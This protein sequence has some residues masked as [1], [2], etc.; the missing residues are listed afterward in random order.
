V[1]VVGYVQHPGEILFEGTPTLLNAIGRAGLLS[2]TTTVT[3]DGVVTNG[4][5][6]GIPEKCTIYRGNDQSVQ[7]ELRALLTS[8]NALAD[9]RL[10]RNDVVYV[11]QPKELFVS[12]MGQVNHPGTVPLTPE[13]TLTSILTQAGGFTDGAGGSP[14]IHILQ[15][16]VGKDIVVPYK[17][18]MTLAGQKE[19]TLHSGDVI[20]INKTGFEKATY[21]LQRISPIA[22]MVSLAA[23]VGAG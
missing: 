1:R 15:P 17:K 18:L 9:M 21:V 2:N 4:S 23:L 19:F 12:V 8:G 13:S 22:T 16:S 6:G 5:G 7:V 20:I 11:P 3:K 10:R 14:N